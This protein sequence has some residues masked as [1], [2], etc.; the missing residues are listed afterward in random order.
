MQNKC[1]SG[2]TC[3]DWPQSHT[4]QMSQEKDLFYTRQ[5]NQPLLR[6]A[7]GPPLCERPATASPVNLLMHCTK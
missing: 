1:L 6:T 7:T 4:W 2:R 5:D 3:R